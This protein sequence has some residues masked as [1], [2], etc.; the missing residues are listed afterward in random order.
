M[1][2]LAVRYDM[3]YEFCAGCVEKEIPYAYG[4]GH[5]EPPFEPSPGE[6]PNEDVI[7]YDC[8]GLVSAALHAGGLLAKP[9][10]RAALVVAQLA[11]WGKA[12]QG[13]ITVWVRNDRVQQ[14]CFFEF[15]GY[16][17]RY[18][19]AS[20]PGTNVR[21]LPAETFTGFLPRTVDLAVFS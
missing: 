15:S 17:H 13:E 19:E 1:T 20:H 12:G 7:G 4:G 3:V 8:A 16:E 9:A 6:P 18:C 14:H 11:V 2:S 5:G 10:A 21:W